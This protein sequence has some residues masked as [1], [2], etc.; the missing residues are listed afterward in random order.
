L[1]KGSYKLRIDIEDF[2]GDARYAVY[3]VFIVRDEASQYLLDIDGYSRNACKMINL[4]SNANPTKNQRCNQVLRN[5]QLFLLH[6]WQSLSIA[7]KV[8]SPIFSLTSQGSYKLRIDIEDFSGD[9]RYAVYDVFI[10]RDEASQYLLD[11]DGYSG[12]A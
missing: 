2:S 4:L 5:G 12:N 9:A 8:V 6:M 7:T 11:I 10:V 1:H 3:D